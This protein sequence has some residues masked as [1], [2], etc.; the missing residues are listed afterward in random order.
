M[1]VTAR[2]ITGESFSNAERHLGQTVR[3][4][5]TERGV[6]NKILEFWTSTDIANP[7]AAIEHLEVL[8]AMAGEE[9]TAQIYDFSDKGGASWG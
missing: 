5:R 7:D 4:R 1:F 6:S 8:T 2:T 3:R 9:V